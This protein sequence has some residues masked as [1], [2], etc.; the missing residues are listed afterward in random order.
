MH[1]GVRL[2]F[3]LA[4]MWVGVFWK[5]TTEE[6]VEVVDGES[7]IMSRPRVD[8]WVCLLPC[9]PLHFVAVGNWTVDFVPYV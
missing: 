4:D 3:K 9:L 5:R 2:E 6:S 7:Q 8:V 1:L